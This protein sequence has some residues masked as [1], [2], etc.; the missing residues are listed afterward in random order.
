M[1]RHG[2]DEPARPWSKPL[3]TGGRDVAKA[4]TARPGLLAGK[5]R[6]EDCAQPHDANDRTDGRQQS[7]RP[8]NQL[9]SR[10]EQQH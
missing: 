1:A 7:R 8:D 10:E 9:R 5:D 3:E 6:R 4:E 2:R